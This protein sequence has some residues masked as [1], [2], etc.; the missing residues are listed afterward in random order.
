MDK[1]LPSEG[2]GHT[3]ESCRVRHEMTQSN[4]GAGRLKSNSPQLTKNNPALAQ[5]LRQ[6]ADA[7]AAFGSAGMTVAA[8]NAPIFAYATEEL[9]SQLP[10]VNG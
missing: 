10:T 4:P 2:K 8:T 5:N 9:M 7:T 1:A 3:F 6:W